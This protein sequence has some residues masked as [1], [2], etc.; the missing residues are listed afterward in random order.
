VFK[1]LVDGD[2]GGGLDDGE[3]EF[4]SAFPASRDAP[5]VFQPAV[6]A[7]DRPAFPCERVAWS[8]SATV[9]AAHGRCAGRDRV[10]RPAPLADH[11]LDPA[12]A[13]LPAQ[14]GAVVAAVCPELSRREATHKQP[15]NQR[16]KMPPLVLVAGA[17]PDRKRRPGSVDC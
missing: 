15:V 9:R 10:S 13:Q 7:F 14:L 12:L 16:Q 8:G 6:G 3:P 5:P 1:G 4:W 2:G 17:D 11:R